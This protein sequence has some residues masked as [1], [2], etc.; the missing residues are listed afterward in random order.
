MIATSSVSPLS[1]IEFALILVVVL[2]GIFLYTV[3]KLRE[4][5]ATLQEQANTA[6]E[7]IIDSMQ[8]QITELQKTV[9]ELKA[10]NKAQARDLD[11]LNE[12]VT[13][14]AKVDALREEMQAGHAEILAAVAAR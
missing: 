2:A 3:S 12:Q 6:Q 13:Q 14:T 11:R 4:G 10:V 7:Q 8:I 9:D 1:I 5:T